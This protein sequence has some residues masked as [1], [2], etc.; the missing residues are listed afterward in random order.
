MT[1]KPLGAVGRRGS[2]PAAL[3]IF[4]FLAVV[5]LLVATGHAPHLYLAIVYL[6]IAV[7]VLT[8]LQPANHDEPH[9]FD[10]DAGFRPDMGWDEDPAGCACCG[11]DAPADED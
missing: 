11:T 5:G 2:L 10:P 6:L 8:R 3:I 4:S 7:F 1:R 9:D